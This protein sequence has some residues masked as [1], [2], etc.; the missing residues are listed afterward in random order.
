[1]LL[2]TVAI[3]DIFEPSPFNIATRPNLPAVLLAQIDQARAIIPS[4]HHKMPR[5]TLLYR[6]PLPH[7]FISTTGPSYMAMPMCVPPPLSRKL[8]IDTLVNS[9]RRRK[10][11]RLEMVIRFL[12]KSGRGLIHILRVCLARLQYRF[13]SMYSRKSMRLFSLSAGLK[14]IENSGFY[15]TSCSTNI[16][17][18]LPSILLLSNL[19]AIENQAV[20]RPLLSQRHTS[21]LSLTQNQRKC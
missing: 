18:L 10:E 9:I 5:H 8:V 1:L 15:L 3:C 11:R 6:I 14:A 21:V 19:I 13:D 12:K 7:T 2:P 4:A 20:R 17:T 16:I